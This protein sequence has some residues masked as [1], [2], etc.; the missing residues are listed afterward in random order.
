MRRAV[1]AAAVGLTIGLGGVAPGMGGN[2][3]KPSIAIPVDPG[4]KAADPVAR[5]IA[6]VLYAHEK[7]FAGGSFV[8]SRSELYFAGGAKGVNALLA[9]LARA[10]GATLVVRLSKEA[11]EAR[12][13][14]PAGVA[15]AEPPCD[16][17]VD[18]LGGSLARAVTVTVY[19]GGGRIDPA[20]LE[21][22]AVAGRA[23]RAGN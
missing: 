19:L 6:A 12:R 5:G 3:D 18:H 8:N 9:D 7:G 10:E 4:T 21:L 16:C 20:E 11:G 2:L 15:R 14:F 13:K 17:K 1:S 23:P 22:P